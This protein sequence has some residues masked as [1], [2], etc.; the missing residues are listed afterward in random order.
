MRYAFWYIFSGFRADDRILNI[1][2]LRVVKRKIT[3]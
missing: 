3:V 1:V 2:N